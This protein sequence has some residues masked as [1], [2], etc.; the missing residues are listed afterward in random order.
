MTIDDW[1]EVMDGAQAHLEGFSDPTG[2]G[3][4]DRKDSER[5]TAELSF[6][7][8]VSILDCVVL[9]DPGTSNHWM[10]VRHPV[11]AGMVA[12]LSHDGDSRIGH[13]DLDSFMA[14]ACETSERDGDIELDAPDVVLRVPDRLVMEEL[15]ASI[16]DADDRDQVEFV[17]HPRGMERIG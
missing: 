8:A 11:A 7:P 9:S 5:T 4:L 3:L 12:L 1:F 13:P 10:L 6:H 15:L 17:L 14:F 16:A 2:V